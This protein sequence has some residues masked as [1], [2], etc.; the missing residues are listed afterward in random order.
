MVGFVLPE[1]HYSSDIQD[2]KSEYIKER[3]FVKFSLTCSE[4]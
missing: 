1:K 3:S 2:R 4:V